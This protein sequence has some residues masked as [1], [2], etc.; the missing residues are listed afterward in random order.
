MD[1]VQNVWSIYPLIHVW[2]RERL[3]IEQ[4]KR[5]SSKARYILVYAIANASARNNPL[6]KH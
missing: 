6:F 4:Q 1:L 5:L 3:D 2:L